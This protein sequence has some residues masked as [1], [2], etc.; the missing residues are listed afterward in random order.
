MGRE[1]AGR[2]RRPQRRL[3]HE[4]QGELLGNA[5]AESFF[6]TLETELVHTRRFATRAEAH[7][8]IFHFVEVFNNRR[9]RHSTLGYLSPIDS[10]IKF[11]EETMSVEYKEPATVHGSGPSRSVSSAP[12]D[13]A[14]RPR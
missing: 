12:E 1:S 2:A 6:A 8:A 7:A 9:R 10:E 3:Q 4:P 13:T 5:V 14:A 11:V